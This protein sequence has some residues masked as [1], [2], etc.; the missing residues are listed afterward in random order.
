MAPY[1]R[2][3]MNAEPPC[4]ITKVRSPAGTSV[5]QSEIIYAGRKNLKPASEKKLSAF[6]WPSRKPASIFLQSSSFSK[7]PTSSSGSHPSK[8]PCRKRPPGCTL[9][10]KA[11]RIFSITFSLSLMPTLQEVPSL[12]TFTIVNHRRQS[13]GTLLYVARKI[14]A[15]RRRGTLPAMDSRSPLS[16]GQASRE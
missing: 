6:A 16:R 11:L 9:L 13:V 5:L 2:G 3:L 8:L 4:L 1:L 12:L 14:G 10:A 7:G 15:R